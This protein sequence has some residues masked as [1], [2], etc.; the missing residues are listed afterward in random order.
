MVQN[1][2]KSF[3]KWLHLLPKWC[4]LKTS[5]LYFILDGFSSS[6]RRQPNISSSTDS[7]M[8]F[9]HHRILLILLFYLKGTSAN[10]CGSFEDVSVFVRL[11][12]VNDFYNFKRF[13]FC[14]FVFKRKFQRR[15]GTFLQNGWT[16]RLEIS[17]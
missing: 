13:F 5:S 7:I 14:F 6:Y 8:A 1:F 2:T 3:T 15:Y 12:S 9:K 16:G 17:H 11:V 10:S 4:L